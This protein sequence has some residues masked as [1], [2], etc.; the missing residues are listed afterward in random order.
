MEPEGPESKRQRIVAGLPK[1]SLMIQVDEITVSYVAT[2][3]IDYII[4]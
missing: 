2:H 3:E 1:C 4:V